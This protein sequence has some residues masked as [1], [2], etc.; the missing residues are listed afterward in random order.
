MQEKYIKIDEYGTKIY[1]KDREMSIIHRNDGPAIEYSSGSKEWWVDGVMHREDGPAA[2]LVS[3]PRKEWWINGKLHREDGP[4]IEYGSNSYG[5]PE[6]CAYYI[7]GERYT[8]K[9]HYTQ[10]IA[11]KKELR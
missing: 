6:H 9:E 7:D 2:I 8:D 3:K 1:Y 11:R 5:Y 4:A 10:A